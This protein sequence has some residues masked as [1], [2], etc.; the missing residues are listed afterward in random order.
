MSDDD[1]HFQ[2]IHIIEH[3]AVT[4][5]KSTS[6]TPFLS[7]MPTLTPA[8]TA[9]GPALAS[10]AYAPALA[11]VYFQETPASAFASGPEALACANGTLV[12]SAS[13]LTTV[14]EASEIERKHY[15]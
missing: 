5:P 15:T 3:G 11:P 14:A 10:P 1:V 13:T 9:N 8:L 2:S 4:G 12:N 7:P 6:G